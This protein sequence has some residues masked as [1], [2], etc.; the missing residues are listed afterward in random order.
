MKKSRPAEGGG[1]WMD[2]YGDMVTLL[3]CFF[4]MLYSMS[5]LDAAKW[6]IFVRSIGGITEDVETEITI[7]G[8][9]E[10]SASKGTPPDE[11]EIG[12]TID[13]ETLYLTI[14]QALKDAGIDGVSTSRGDGYTYVE[15]QDKAFFDG[16]SSVLTPQGKMTLQ[17][18]GMAIAPAA[19]Q[20]EQIDIMAHTAQ[21]DPDRPNTPRTDRMLS[22]MRA[23]E[24]CIFLQAMDIIEPEKLIDISYGQFRPIASNDTRE[25]RAKNRRVELLLID[26]GVEMKSL[27]AYYQEHLSGA[28]ADRTVN[29]SDNLNPDSEDPAF[30][31]AE[32]A[33][34]EIGVTLNGPIVTERESNVAFIRTDGSGQGKPSEEESEEFLSGA[35]EIPAPAQQTGEALP[36]VSGETLPTDSALPEDSFAGGEST[37][38]LAGRKEPP[39]RT[40]TEIQQ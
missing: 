33:G 15:F 35:E 22:A 40:E 6:D 9:I 14:A 32:A 3:L 38:P 34:Q 25:G 28:N 5:S 10:D 11:G 24:V 21:G 2:T 23:A 19:E 36:E 37:T 1:N 16:N 29:T 31:E 7:N 20:L 30:A 4:V 27:D 17:A 39:I 13:M 8:E 18:F 12:N 26:K